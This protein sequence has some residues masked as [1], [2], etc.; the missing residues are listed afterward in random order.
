[1]LSQAYYHIAHKIRDKYPDAVFYA[2]SRLRFRYM[3]VEDWNNTFVWLRE[4]APSEELR[5]GYK[6]NIIS[7]EEY[8]PRYLA[9][10]NNPNSKELMLKIAQEAA[11]KPVFIFCHCGPKE[12]KKCHRFLLLDLISAAAKEAGINIEIKS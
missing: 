5:K 3:K 4:L 11:V 10:M 12:G 8:K 6:S 7:W 1:M 2:V 9:E